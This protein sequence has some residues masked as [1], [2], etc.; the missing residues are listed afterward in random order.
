M[1]KLVKIVSWLFAAGSIVLIAGSFYIYAVMVPELPSIEHLEDTQYQVPLRVYDQNEILLA[2]FGEHRRIP[3]SFEKIPRSLIDAVVAVEDDQFW[4]HVGVDFFALLAATYEVVTTGRKTRGGSTVTMQVA[5]N[6]F[7]SPEQTY[8]RKFNEILLALKIES[9]LSKEK[10]MELYLNKIFL[11]HRSYGISAASQA[12]YDKKLEDL[13]LAQAAMIAGLPKAPSKY[14]PISNPERALIRRNY[15]LGRMR[16]LKYIDEE[17]FELALNEPITAELHKTRTIADAQY[18]SEL[19]RAELFEQ[20]GEEI[21][22]AGLKVYTSI[23]GEMQ[24]VANR[25]LRRA[26]LDYNRRHGYRG[27]VGNID[28][29]EIREDPFDEDLI[30]DNRVG[31]LRKGVVISI[32]EEA[33]I[34]DETDDQGEAKMSPASAT[35]LISNYEQIDVPFEGGIDW[36]AAF[37][38]EDNQGPK[39]EKVAD[40][41]AVGDVIWVEQREAQWLL[42]EVPRIEG[43]LVSIDP[44]NGGIQAMVGGFDYFKNKFNR[45]TQARRQPGSNFKPFIY[46]AALEK[47]YTAASIINDAPVVFD[48]D[49][50]EATWRPENYSGKFY[51]PTRLREALVKSRNLVSIRILQSIGLR[52]ATNYIQRFGFEREQMPYDLSLALGSASFSPLQMARAYTVFSNGGYLIE[53]YIISRVELGNGDVIYQNQPLTVCQGCEAEDLEALAEAEAQAA[54]QQ[55]VEVQQAAEQQAAE[56]Q[57]A[58]Q[59]AAEQQAAEQQAAEQQT[60]RAAET[61]ALSDEEQLEETELDELKDGN[62]DAATIFKVIEVVAEPSYAPRVISAQNAFIMRSIMREVVQRGTAVRAKALGRKDIAGKTGTTN[63]QIDAWFSGFNDQVVTTTWVGYDNQ[64]KMGRRETGGRAALPMW[65]EFMKVALDGRPENLQEQP[66][67]LV[68]I[69]IDAESGDRA[70]LDTR[71]SLFEVFR[72][73][74]APREQAVKSTTGDSTGIIVN[75]PESEE[76]IVEDIF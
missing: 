29:A 50:L 3:V 8:S 22:K 67:G 63:D 70:D 40:V 59:Q 44:S 26:L 5:R 24:A 65:I 72:E 71:N 38:D 21:Y 69:R 16:I 61:A 37:V 52:Y 12:Y 60:G 9:E 17:A 57:A 36:A 55:E 4:N 18:V 35:V 75:V 27:V 54:A 31:G 39:P 66:Q 42:A 2:E 19:V 25:A 10:I 45:A 34:V 11:G 7:L 53:P 30:T 68:T 6:F 28:L 64:R 73:E 58:E 49:S 43:A 13:T 20:Y 46:S 48:D 74:N 1:K 23:D 33:P 47:G 56:Q 15:I 76:E 32:N 62:S 14:N 41:L 51:G